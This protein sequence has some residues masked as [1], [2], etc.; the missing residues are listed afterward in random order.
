MLRGTDGADGAI[1]VVVVVL[2]VVEVVEV[3]ELDEVVAA[4]VAGA[5]VVVVVVVLDVEDVWAIA[6]STRSRLDTVAIA[7]TEPSTRLRRGG[8]GRPNEWIQ[9]ELLEEVRSW[10]VPM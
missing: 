4:V 9:D 8:R 6:E 3:D 2:V 1:V 5:V 7:T 10:K